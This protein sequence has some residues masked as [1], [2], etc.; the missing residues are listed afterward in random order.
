M[1]N[2]CFN[3]E[4]LIIMSKKTE[5]IQEYIDKLQSS[6]NDLS[7]IDSSVDDYTSILRGVADIAI[8][9]ANVFATYYPELK[10]FNITSFNMVERETNSLIGILRAKIIDESEDE[11]NNKM[12]EVNPLEILTIEYPG[13]RETILDYSDDANIV[14]YLNQ[15]K[16]SIQEPNIDTIRYCLDKIALW[17]KNN[18]SEIETNTYV[19]NVDSHIQ[20][21][22]LL[23]KLIQD[24]RNYTPVT[25]TTNNKTSDTMPPKNS[26]KLV[27]L[28]H[29]SESKP[30]ADAIASLIRGLGVPNDK[31]VYTSHPLHKI[32][33]DKNIYEYLRSKINSNV[34]VIFLWSNEYLMSPVCMNEMGAA[35]ITQKD[36]TN[37]YVPDFNFNNPKYRECVVDTDK[38]GAVL[39]ND[40][41]C[42]IDMIK[43]KD[44][45]LS[46]FNLNVTEENSTYL[47]DEFME[48]IAKLN[49][50]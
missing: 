44:K 18:I 36:Y 39:R 32:P 24:F 17:Y 8:E 22:N 10:D 46:M 26:D 23:D 28:S 29:K 13:I 19:Y 14:N 50:I 37:I 12:Y 34:F 21:K 49:N 47:I 31:L 45:I 1:K 3:G 9:T 33:L 27:F 11:Q 38:M 16:Y 5:F 42:K 43:L 7:N 40:K 48:S 41:N 30:Y 25:A 4:V 2:R 20:N 6:L 35:W 15:I